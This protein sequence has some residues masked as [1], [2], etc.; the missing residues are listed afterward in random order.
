VNGSAIHFNNC[1][2]K[3]HSDLEMDKIE[4]LLVLVLELGFVAS[5]IY[6][7]GYLVGWW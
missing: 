5:L 3:N 4:R 7:I 2:E 1:V 6:L